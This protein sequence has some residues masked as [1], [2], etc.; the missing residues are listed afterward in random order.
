MPA[1]GLLTAGSLAVGLGEAIYGGI[2]SKKINNQLAA[3]AAARPK[4]QIP[5][6]ENN[7]ESLAESRGGQ[8]ISD[9][10][11]TANQNQSN[12]NTAAA[13]AAIKQSG[14]T[15]NIGAITG[16]AD[17][18]SNQQAIYNDQARMQNLNNLQGAYAR[19]SAN[20]DKQFQVNELDPW[21]DKQ[22]FLSTQ[23]AGAKNTEQ[24]GINTAASGAMNLGSSLLKANT[25]AN[26]AANIPVAS[27]IPA[28][29]PSSAN[30][31]ALTPG[32]SF[33]VQGGGDPSFNPLLAAGSGSG[34]STSLGNQYAN[35]W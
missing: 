31:P 17:N 14:D 32:G 30:I 13:L 18:A 20:K 8:G 3:N 16:A 25:V 2:Q 11:M 7:I 4:Y 33:N 5:Q 1:G 15:S 10:A 23:L 29:Q 12:Q 28:I 19:M 35:I 26:P 22:Q 27:S 21:K 34:Q 24:A 9:A 6:E